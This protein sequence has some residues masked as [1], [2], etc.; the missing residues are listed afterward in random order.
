MIG[1]AD[2]ALPKGLDRRRLQE[3]IEAVRRRLA[4]PAL[5]EDGR[6]YLERL[7]ETY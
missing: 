5:D 4:D 3:V 6:R 2:L 7:L 1:G